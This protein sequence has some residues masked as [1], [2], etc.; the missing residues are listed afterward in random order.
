MKEKKEKMQFSRSKT[1][2]TAIAL[3]L[4]LTITATFVALP[5]ANAHTP[6]WTI[7][8]NAYVSAAPNPIGVGQ[9]TTIVVWVDENPPTASGTSGPRW[10]GYK[11]D[12]T[13]PD[14]SKETIG[15]FTERS[16]TGSDFVQYTPDQVGTYTIVFS[17][18]GETLANMTGVG[19]RATGIP[20]IGDY[21]E[22]STSAPLT[23]VVQ[24]EPITE[25]Q[26]PPLPTEFWTTP[27]NGAN[28][29]WSTLASNYLKGSWLVN[30]FQRWGTAPESP[31][32]LWTQP[33][34]P[35]LAGGINDAAWP[36]QP[37]DV[38]DYEGP[39]SSPI[40]MNGKIYYNQPPVSDVASYGYYCLD[41]YTGEQVWYK[42][43][44]D[45]GLNNPVTYST[46]HGTYL[47][48]SYLGPT[49]GWLYHYD[50]V[51]GQGILAYLLAVQGSTWYLLDPSTG[52]Y[53]MT[54]VNVPSGTSVTD[55]DGSLLRYSYNARTGN[56]LCWNISQSIPPGGPTGTGE[57]QWRTWPG[58]IIDAVND[59]TWFKLGLNPPGV[60][61]GTFYA[62][63]N[64]IL[65]RSGY[66]MNVTIQAGLPGSISVVQDANRVPKMIFGSYI[67]SDSVLGASPTADTFSA[68]IARIDEHVAPYSPFPDK[69]YTQNNN[70]G[71]GVTLLWN[72]NFTVPVPGHN[73]TWSISAPDSSDN[74]VFVLSCKQTMQKWGYDAMTGNLLWGPTASEGTFNY[75]GMGSNAYGDIILSTGYCGT[76]YAYN[77]LTGELLWT[78][79]ATTIGRESPYG[80]NYPLSIGAVCDGKV[81]LYSTEHSPT[82]PLWRGSYLRCVNLTDGTELWKLLDFNQG[83]SIADGCIVTS[84]QYDNNIYCIGQG[85]SA[86]TVTASPEVSVHGD[87]VLIKGMATD[88]SPGAK[89]IVQASRFPNGVPAVADESMQGWMEY[90]YEQQALPANAKGVE[91]TLDAVD[92]NGNF[93]H[94][95]T[96]TSDTSGMF[97]K[98]FTPEVPGE[99]TIIAT[100]AGSK[101]YYASYAETAISV[102][103]AAPATQP[104]QY[105]V[106]ADYTLTI[107]GTGIAIIIAVAIVGLILLRKR[108]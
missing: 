91:V 44:T 102:S 90:L 89:Q 83:M 56:L 84:S 88:I 87:S 94:I 73:Y 17:W 85:P 5:T 61:V 107:V 95:G 20:Y 19:I 65:P 8:T 35:G 58:A 49:Q 66:T 7:S 69:T 24:Q 28:R 74:P 29:G 25:W 11:L 98:A 34:T 86:V 23:L 46:S 68:W 100:F 92:P 60:P 37:S 40:I 16:A 21:F 27:I 103:E 12:I 14:G 31:H 30:N 57:Q 36:G 76:L 54:L 38:N 10:S 51:N 59:T 99:Y 33:I 3:F 67:A 63:P 9:Y 62:D 81:Y 78:Y 48:T 41:L 55:Q 50:S 43:G 15:P 52:N 77:K 18:P 45:N 75:Y 101:S 39:W 6:A 93:V 64:D 4:V 106:P 2:V 104:P 22:G 71:F 26:E 1:M 32:I 108:P 79:N 53:I 72:K 47:L 97:K 105:P 82:K 42:N 13:K 70:L 96:V 80:E